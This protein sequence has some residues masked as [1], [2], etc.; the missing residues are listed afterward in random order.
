M[1]ED[2]KAKGIMILIEFK[3]TVGLQNFTNFKSSL[4]QIVIVC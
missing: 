3:D 1:Q 2:Q 4:F